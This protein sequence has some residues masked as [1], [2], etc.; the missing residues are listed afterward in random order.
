M[1]LSGNY[2]SE[3]STAEAAL[4]GHYKHVEHVP[5][6]MIRKTR[7]NFMMDKASIRCGN[8][9]ASLN[10]ATEIACWFVFSGAFSSTVDKAKSVENNGSNM[11]QIDLNERISDFIV[12]E[13]A[14]QIILSVLNVLVEIIVNKP[15][16]FD[17]VPKLLMPRSITGFP[18]GIPNDV[19]KPRS[20]ESR[21]V[22][23]I[24]HHLLSPGKP[25]ETELEVCR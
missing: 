16:N 9:V 12:P 21:R 22:L 7:H 23:S 4:I 8:E 2:I 3:N 14:Q 1:V 15:T 6:S 18:L 24:S 19:A 25:P 10:I 13:Q 5:D 20:K 11:F 17:I